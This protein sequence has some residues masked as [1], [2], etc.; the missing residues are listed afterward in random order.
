MMSIK[1]IILFSIVLFTILA[2]IYFINPKGR[3]I[4]K[5]INLNED[6]A[7]N[8]F[9]LHSIDGKN[10]DL[11]EFDVSLDGVANLKIEFYVRTSEK[12]ISEIPLLVDVYQNN[13]DLSKYDRLIKSE[14]IGSE[15]SKVEI[16]FEF[17]KERP[18]SVKIRAYTLSTSK[19]EISNF[20]IIKGGYDN[21]D[22]IL[23]DLID[24]FLLYIL[25]VLYF[26][27]INYDLRFKENYISAFL[28]L[29]IY[30]LSR[31][32]YPFC[33]DSNGY[34]AYGKFFEKNNQFSIAY[35]DN[36]LRGYLFPLINYWI[37]KFGQ[38]LQVS[39][40][41]SFRFF[42]SLFYA[43]LIIEIIPLF[44][45]E[46][47]EKVI[48]FRERIIVL[49]LFFIFWRGYVLYPLTDFIAFSSMITAAMLLLRIYK[50][51]RIKLRICFLIGALVFSCL[52]LRPSYIIILVP[53][54]IISTFLIFSVKFQEEKRV[55][56]CFKSLV[57]ISMI[58]LGMFLVALPQIIINNVHFQSTSPFVQMEKYFNGKNLM[59][60]KLYNGL[61]I[62]KYE[63]YIGKE[64]DSS[65]AL[66][67]DVTG[68]EIITS[69]K[70]T[71]INS[72]PDYFKLVLKH[73]IQFFQIYLKHLFNGLD[74]RFSTPY[75]VKFHSFI[76]TTLIQLINFTIM[77]LTILLVAY[78]LKKR[79][80][81]GNIYSILFLLVIVL[82]GFISLPTEPEVRFYMPLSIIFISWVVAEIDNL[83]KHLKFDRSVIL[84]FSF[85]FLMMYISYK[86]NENLYFM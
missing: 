5:L 57:P 2:L 85:L 30:C 76:E 17:G 47:F 50:T 56:N 59:L 64:Y 70:I 66:L 27:N 8:S 23:L 49:I 20:K 75:V 68:K 62:Q 31:E 37:F 19:I 11:R 41:N 52:N 58:F 7:S 36:A 10:V 72:Y 12:I 35:Y 21:S 63:T 22:E 40:V 43:Y 33:H 3:N 54:L 16:L 51:K 26:L 6:I 29:F 69:E 44:I 1:K 61:T 24:I 60:S 55:F 46:I 42:S 32:S 80:L 86:L 82:P 38:L 14:Q 4:L 65:V 9:Y 81:F 84:Y 78:K 15:F 25:I 71:E 67:N 45:S 28:V 48:E 79:S 77:Y 53:F 18:S 73:P 74:I 83:V 34:W 39:E 13:F